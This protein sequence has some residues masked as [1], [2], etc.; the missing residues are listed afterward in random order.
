MLVCGRSAKCQRRC[1][2]KKRKTCFVSPPSFIPIVGDCQLPASIQA[3]RLDSIYRFV[4]VQMSSTLYPVH[5]PLYC[6]WLRKPLWAG[7]LFLMGKPLHLPALLSGYS[8]WC[9]VV[10]RRF[11]HL[12]YSLHI[13]QNLQLF[14]AFRMERF[15]WPGFPRWELKKPC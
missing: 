11:C 12:V 5:C 10:Q 13:R 1:L 2:R 8:G 15:F 6:T 9:S 4:H 14:T 3:S 7:R